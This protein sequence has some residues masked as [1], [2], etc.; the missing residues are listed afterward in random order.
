MK[1]LIVGGGGR[2]HALAWK[3]AASPRVS[4]VFVAPGNAGTASETKVSN[5]EI[6][7]LD[8]EALRRFA[9][10]TAIDLT[11]VGP[12]GPLVAGI[13]DHFQAAG[14]RCFGPSKAAAQ[15]EGSKAYSK[16][17]LSRHGIPTAGFRTFTAETFDPYY[18]RHQRLPLVI[19]AD[20]LAAGKGVVICER[21]DEAVRTAEQML[22]G[23]FGA[24]GASS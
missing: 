21:A 14:L 3:C 16:A 4:R 23:S 9:Q 10:E 8:L 18:V 24:A 11:I 2:E 13:V 20:G 1:V 7:A 17:F 19:K 5:V 15:L 12:E 22:A 6:D